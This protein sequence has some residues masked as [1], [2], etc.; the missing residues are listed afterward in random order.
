[1]INET[2]T[3]IYE[4]NNKK[5]YNKETNIRMKNS[6]KKIEKRNIDEENCHIN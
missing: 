1:M 3:F 5:N 4:L 6:S 2:T